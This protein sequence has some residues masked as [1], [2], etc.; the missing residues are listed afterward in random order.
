MYYK[1]YIDSVFILQFMTDLYLLSLAGR[2]LRCT[3]THG[4]KCLGAVS[5]AVLSC[6]VIVIPVGSMGGRMLISALPVSMGMMC[7]T[8]RI[9]SM[10]K[11][12]HSSLVMAGCGFFLGSIMIWILNRL[13]VFLKSRETLFLTI[14]IGYLAYRILAAVLERFISRSRNN[15]RT[16][17]FYVPAFSQEIRVRAFVDTGDHL[18]DPVSGVPVS[19]ISKKIAQCMESC[20]VPEKYHA[21]P[22]RS[23]GKEKG[24]L[25]AY[26]IPAMVIEEE[27][28]E[29]RR[30][31]VIVAICDTGISEES[32]YQMILHPR[33]LEN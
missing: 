3:A 9:H 26:E 22:Y 14:L 31:H 12:I 24:I 18:T 33:L 30:E 4:R 28:R 17:R 2:F 21:V 5:G 20:F 15:L 13:R 29:I 11:L 6:L 10:K 27:G 25:N 32:V 19:V 16:V 1:L 8:Y 7:I 23:V